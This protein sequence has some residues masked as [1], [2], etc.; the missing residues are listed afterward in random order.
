MRNFFG[1]LRFKILSAVLA[2]ILGVMLYS[3]S[4]DGI[5]TLPQKIVSF[6][7]LPVQKTSAVISNSVSDFFSVFIDAEKNEKEN[8]RLKAEIANLR[9]K[10]VDFENTKTENERLREIVGLKEQNA[11]MEL[12]DAG[13]IGRDPAD[14]FGAFTIDKG[15]IHGISKRDPVIT[16]DGLVGYIESL[17]PT[18]AKVIT[19]LSP[20]INVGVVEVRTNET[21]NLTGNISIAGK[22]FTKF[23]LLPKT[24]LITKG[25]II[26][27]A[28]TSGY[29]PPNLVIGTVEEIKL[30]ES[31]ITAFATIRPAS[32]I[33]EIKHVF[34]LT[35][36][37]GKQTAS[38]DAESEG[39]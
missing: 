4:T 16:S 26:V 9:K 35:D 11:D 24:T 14:N 2:V 37:L 32:D 7:V 13:I 10:M 36:F 1:S 39:N 19:I 17:G 3:A 15:S 6:V 28:G 8:E 22:G 20:E 30:E 12:I 33:Y 31:G 5:A 25:D 18:Y 29:Y 23:E 27:T 34:V 38:P 21:G